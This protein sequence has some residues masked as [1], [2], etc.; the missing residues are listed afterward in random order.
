M[1]FGT[2][3]KYSKTKYMQ[4]EVQC[5]I[6]K[7][8]SYAVL[9]VSGLSLDGGGN[10]AKHCLHNSVIVSTWMQITWFL[11]C[12]LSHT[13]HLSAAFSDILCSLLVPVYVRFMVIVFVVQK[14]LHTNNLVQE[15]TWKL[16]PAQEMFF[17][18]FVTFTYVAR[19]TPNT[20]PGKLTKLR[21]IKKNW[22]H[23]N[24]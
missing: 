23:W 19:T 11:L 3:F 15:V 5:F 4:K 18:V 2:I 12:S 10:A 7:Q 17:F 8:K 24:L 14:N 22:K 13:L 6:K 21:T 9:T 20:S 1:I 16:S